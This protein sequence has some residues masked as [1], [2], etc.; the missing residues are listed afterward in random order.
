MKLI[1]QGKVSLSNDPDDPYGKRG[2]IMLS[3]FTDDSGDI[4]FDWKKITT[5]SPYYQHLSLTTLTWN[6]PKEGAK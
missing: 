4:R 3:L 2:N 6:V 1:D 5:L